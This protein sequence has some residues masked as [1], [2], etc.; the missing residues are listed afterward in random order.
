MHSFWIRRKKSTRTFFLIVAALLITVTLFRH[1]LLRFGVE[2]AFRALFAQ[3][4]AYS[5]T[6]E[7]VGWKNGKLCIAGIDLKEERYHLSVDNLS[8]G[9]SWRLFPFSF[10]PD[11]VLTHP[12]VT[13]EPEKTAASPSKLSLP[14]QLLGV[15]VTVENGVLQFPLATGTQRLYFLFKSGV[16]HQGKGSFALS[17]DPDLLNTPLL[18][19]NLQREKQALGVHLRIERTSCSHIT[20]LLAY[21]SSALKSGWENVGGEIDLS[22]SALVNAVG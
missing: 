21:F 1:A 18:T 20:P 13:L 4:R 8:V 9:Y 19:L 16:A 15:Q 3:T 10:A 12:E 17:Y 5:F 2:T 6:Y 7:N 14:L 22:A 11:L